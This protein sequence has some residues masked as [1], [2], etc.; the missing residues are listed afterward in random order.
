MNVGAV[1]GLIQNTFELSGKIVFHGGLHRDLA[2]ASVDDGGVVAFKGFG[3]TSRLLL[4]L[5]SV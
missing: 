3:V 4:L 1:V 5:W 2:G